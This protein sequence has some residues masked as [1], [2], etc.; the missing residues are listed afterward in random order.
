MA[1]A[2]SLLLVADNFRSA[3]T[4]TIYLDFH[5]KFSA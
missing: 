1:F 3:R 4:Y 5:Q 2:V